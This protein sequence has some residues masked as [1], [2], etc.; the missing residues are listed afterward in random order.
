MVSLC[1]QLRHEHT[2]LIAT[3]IKLSFCVKIARVLAI[4]LNSAGVPIKQER[5]MAIA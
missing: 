3:R 1:G 4:N 5:L 2:H